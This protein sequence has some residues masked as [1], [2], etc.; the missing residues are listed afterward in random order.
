MAH[1]R[2][3]VA[4]VAERCIDV[5]KR[6]SEGH[7]LSVASPYPPFFFYEEGGHGATPVAATELSHAGQRKEGA[8]RQKEDPT[9]TIM[10]P[11][12]IISP[13]QQLP[14]PPGGILRRS[15]RVGPY[16][17]T[18]TIDVDTF[19]PGVVGQ[20]NVQWEP[21]LPPKGW[22]NAKRL[23]RYREGRNAIYQEIVN[24]TGKRTLVV[25]V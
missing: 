2:V 22:L 12:T 15:H 16:T 1:P 18:W 9:M 5:L 23:A 3:S 20:T 19:G 11:F 17:I 13:Q 10:P 6:G 7:G 25:D 24:I 4:S 21:D 8:D 14:R